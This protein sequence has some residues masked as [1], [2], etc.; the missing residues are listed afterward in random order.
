MSGRKRTASALL[1]GVFLLASCGDKGVDYPRRFDE[2]VPASWRLNEETGTIK[3]HGCASTAC[4]ELDRVYELRADVATASNELATHLQK[5]QN[6]VVRR[7][8]NGL[9]ADCTDVHLSVS[10]STKSVT[11]AM[12]RQ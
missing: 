6:C 7:A 11:I 8:G 3:S 1:F 5:A 10:F 9:T 2:L 12:T 4:G